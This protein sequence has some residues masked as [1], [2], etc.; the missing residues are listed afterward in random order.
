MI[1]QIINRGYVVGPSSST[2]NSVVTYNGTTGKL[3][4]DNPNLIYD[5]TNLQITS[6]GLSLSGNISA[7]AWTTN[8]IKI[9]SAAGTLTDTSSSGTVALACTNRL[10][11]NTIA[12]SSSTTF[13]KYYSLYITSPVAGTNVS[14]GNGAA[15][16]VDSAVIEGPL[17]V[18][19]SATLYNCLAFTGNFSAS[20]W[21][22][23]GVKIKDTGGTITD[24]TSSGTVSNAYT[25]K[26]GGNTIAASSSTT[27]TNYYGSYFVNPVAGSNVTFTN[28][29]ALGADTLKVAGT[30]RIEGSFT[31]DANTPTVT[32]SEADT[33]QIWSIF[34]AASGMFI[35]ADTTSDNFTI[36]DSSNSNALRLVTSTKVLTIYGDLNLS[37]AINI[38]PGTTTGTQIGSTTA[39]KIAF[40]AATPIVQPTTGV[41]SATFTANTGT[42]VNSGS[43]FDG[44]TLRQVVKALRNIGL[45]A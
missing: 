9:K 5:G 30:T 1:V 19:D 17:V 29:Y 24:T 14:I 11:G 41:A 43:T 6:G 42:T 8:G 34:V 40:W 15:L 4:K 10:G 3:I 28:R 18:V 27:F 13:T 26:F 45:L 33:G 12:A 37:D 21:T 32:L 31:I 38:T 20:A 16:G 39:Q 36:R 44:Y 35:D 23:N 22:T 7:S 25:N 2:N